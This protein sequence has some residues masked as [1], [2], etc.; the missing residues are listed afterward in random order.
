MEDPAFIRLNADLA[1]PSY[2][3]GAV[4]G[5]WRLLYLAFPILMMEVAATEPDG[6]GSYY[7]FRFECTGYAGQKPEVK[8]W[9]AFQNELL[10]PEHRPKG[11]PRVVKSFQSWG[12]ETVYRP[13][14]RKS[15]VHNN[16]E[17][18]YP[19]LAWHENRDLAFILEDLYAIL[20]SNARASHSR[21]AA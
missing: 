7:C 19:T 21:S 12:D 18:D 5:R 20:N 2:K 17:R 10:P 6:S 1:A 8:I 9:D 11:N 16:F 15:A 3:A 4:R 13:W 14:D